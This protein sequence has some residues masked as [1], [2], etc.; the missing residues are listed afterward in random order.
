MYKYTIEQIGDQMGHYLEYTVFEW[1]LWQWSP[2][3]TPYTYI[4][5]IKGYNLYVDARFCVDLSWEVPW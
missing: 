2:S 1:V 3:E 5:S 4:Q